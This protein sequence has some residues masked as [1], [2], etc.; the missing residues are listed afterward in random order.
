MFEDWYRVLHQ[1]YQPDALV[2]SPVTMAELE[3]QMEPMLTK[4]T[5]IETTPTFMGVALKIS[6]HQPDGKI[7]IL[8]RGELVGIIDLGSPPPP[9]QL[10]AAAATD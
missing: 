5:K 6:Q 4:S 2:L 3:R 9:G 1:G 8:Q 7:A 10:S